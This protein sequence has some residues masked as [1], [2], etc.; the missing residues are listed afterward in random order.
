[1][2]T[3]LLNIDKAKL[4]GEHDCPDKSS[5]NQMQKNEIFA[6]NLSQIFWR[7]QGTTI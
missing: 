5:T 1:M 6:E 4:F 2:K 3:Q 7:E